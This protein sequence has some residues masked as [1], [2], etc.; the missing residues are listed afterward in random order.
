M[1][2]DGKMVLTLFDTGS[3][4]YPDSSGQGAQTTQKKLSTSLQTLLLTFPVT[5]HT[6]LYITVPSMCRGSL[7][8][9]LR[10][11]GANTSAKHVEDISFGA[12]CYGSCQ[13]DRYTIQRR[14]YYFSYH[15]RCRE[16]CQKDD[17]TPTRK[18]CTYMCARQT[19]AR[20]ERT[21]EDNLHE[22]QS[23]ITTEDRGEELD[24]EL[25]DAL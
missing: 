19:R 3:C 4:G 18:V 6:L 24:Y 13:K 22:E 23:D 1:Q 5:S 8:E 2:F 14:A 9:A 11:S 25:S 16:R 10:S 15:Q 12:V 21:S 7:A 20:L 17:H